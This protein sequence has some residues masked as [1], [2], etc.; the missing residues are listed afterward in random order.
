MFECLYYTLY[1]IKHTNTHSHEMV[2]RND[3]FSLAIPA[4]QTV[5]DR[6]DPK[7][8]FCQAENATTLVRTNVKIVNENKISSFLQSAVLFLYHLTFTENISFSDY[9]QIKPCKYGDY[10]SILNLD[11]AHWFHLPPRITFSL[12]NFRVAVYWSFSHWDDLS[13]NLFFVCTFRKLFRLGLSGRI[14]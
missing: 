2:Y 9:L 11:F 7:L 14:L 10:N 8:N 6:S 1:P 3:V 13:I 12:Y 4:V 5:C